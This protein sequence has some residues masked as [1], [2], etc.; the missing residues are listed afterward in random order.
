MISMSNQEVAAYSTQQGPLMYL[1]KLWY[2]TDANLLQCLQDE[3]L[4]RVMSFTGVSLVKKYQ[5]I[6]FPDQDSSVVFLILEGRVK[7]SRLRED[8]H[9]ETFNLLAP[10]HLFGERPVRGENSRNESAEA[11]DDVV[12]CA[13]GSNSFQAMLEEAPELFLP[14]AKQIKLQLSH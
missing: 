2:I 4:Q 1:T 8:G 6:H 11:L 9:S 7:L 13:I 14:L 5:D 10:G 12:I 3:R